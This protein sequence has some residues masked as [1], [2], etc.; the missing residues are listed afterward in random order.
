MSKKILAENGCLASKPKYHNSAG[1]S[2]HLKT[3]CSIYWAR[4]DRPPGH[5]QV[6]AH[7]PLSGDDKLHPVPTLFLH[8]LNTSHQLNKGLD[9]YSWQNTGF[10]KAEASSVMWGCGVHHWIHVQWQKQNAELSWR[11]TY[12]SMYFPL[13]VMC[14]QHAKMVNHNKQKQSNGIL[15]I[16]KETNIQQMCCI[17]QPS[18][19][20]L[21]PTINKK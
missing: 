9:D 18:I 8:L 6:S 19:K 15:Q 16:L 11:Q 1:C 14:V 12:A 17:H 2:S 3:T 10:R 21:M 7:W 5:L 4:T 13:K 20:T